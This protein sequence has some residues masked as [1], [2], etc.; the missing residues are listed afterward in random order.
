MSVI[1]HLQVSTILHNITAGHPALNLTSRTKISEKYWG[2]SSP[3]ESVVIFQDGN[4]LTGVLDKSQIGASP[5]GLVHSCYELYGGMTTGR[6]LGILGRLF[7]AYVQQSGFTC[8]MDDLQLTPQGDNNRKQQL[9][10]CNSIGKQA[11]WDHIGIGNS[12]ATENNLAVQAG[13]C[14]SCSC[15][16]WCS[17]HLALPQPT[18]MY[19]I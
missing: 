14:A 19:R 13:W 17:T 10:K 1:L 2:S 12:T 9:D 7:T 5:Y 15:I 18:L 4:M 11:V 8:R 6:L 16:A 3:E